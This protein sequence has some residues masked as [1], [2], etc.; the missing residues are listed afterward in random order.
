MGVLS[1]LQIP[2]LS[3]V[4]EFHKQRS[5]FRFDSNLIARF[6]LIL[7]HSK[8]RSTYFSLREVSNMNQSKNP[9]LKK[10]HSV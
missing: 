5:I 6:P 1:G 2:N 10:V 8:Y 9:S 4:G 3:T 7:D